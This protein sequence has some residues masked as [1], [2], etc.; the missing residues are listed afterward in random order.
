M[1]NISK[2]REIQ[3]VTAFVV[4]SVLFH[5]NTYIEPLTDFDEYIFLHLSEEMKWYG[6]NYSTKSFFN[7]KV[8]RKSTFRKDTK[9][10]SVYEA[11]VFHHPPLYPFLVR[12]EAAFSF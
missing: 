8:F 9:R 7:K 2:I 3:I 12:E 5:I 10:R 11:Q 1:N 6:D 4:L